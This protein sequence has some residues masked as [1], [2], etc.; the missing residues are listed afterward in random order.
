[1]TLR[2]PVISPIRD[3]VSRLSVVGWLITCMFTQWQYDGQ[4]AVHYYTVYRPACFMI[5]PFTDG[6]HFVGAG[7]CID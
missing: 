1:M 6:A 3:D 7:M 5:G 2:F 4:K